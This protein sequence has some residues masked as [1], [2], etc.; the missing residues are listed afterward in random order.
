MEA[1]SGASLAAG[2]RDVAR[3]GIARRGGGT[4]RS[5]DK[6]GL[7]VMRKLY[8]TIG[9]AEII[10]LTHVPAHVRGQSWKSHPTA[11]GSETTHQSHDATADAGRH[12]AP[13]YI[14]GMD[15]SVLVVGL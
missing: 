8:Y 6:R 10:K 15:E 1:P 13:Q 4:V 12:S 2:S 14:R 5:K 7:T 9:I 3:G 11:L